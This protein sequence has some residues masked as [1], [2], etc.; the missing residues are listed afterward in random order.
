MKKYIFICVTIFSLAM[1]AVAIDF[2]MKVTIDPEVLGS[3]TLS[4]IAYN[5]FSK[6][7]VAGEERQFTNKWA[8]EKAQ[9]RWASVCNIYLPNKKG[10]YLL[11]VSLNEQKDTE[12]WMAGAD[13][14]A[15]WDFFVSK[16]GEIKNLKLEGR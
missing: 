12:C 9:D 1:S 6:V 7:I 14:P 5:D 13:A 16:N 2:Q 8:Y 15:G 11:S 10:E 3:S 4:F